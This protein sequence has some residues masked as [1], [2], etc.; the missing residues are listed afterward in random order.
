MRIAK[1]VVGFGL[2]LAGIVMLVTPGPGWLTI[3][4]GLAMLAG[5][6]P[7]ARRAL[8]SIK[9]LRPHGGSGGHRSIHMATTLG[10]QVARWVTVLS[11]HVIARNAFH[12]CCVVTGRIAAAP[13]YPEQCFTTKKAGS[14]AG[15]RTV[16]RQ[17]RCR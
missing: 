17:R 5:E 3:A 12:G 13:T 6:F 1:V 9:S 7:W 16:K 15:P 14:L 8:D 11:R 10:K 2:L 4:G